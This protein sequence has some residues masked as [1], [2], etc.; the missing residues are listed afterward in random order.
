MKYQD[1]RARFAA[2][3]EKHKDCCSSHSLADLLLMDADDAG[4]L[5]PTNTCTLEPD[6]LRPGMT[7]HSECK[8]EW[9]DGPRKKS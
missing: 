5:P 7:K 4:M 8:R 2:I 3:I 1:M 9:D 6:P